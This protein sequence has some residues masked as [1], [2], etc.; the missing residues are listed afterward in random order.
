VTRRVAVTGANGFVGRNLVAAARA[1]GWEVTGVVRSPA[2]AAQVEAA[3]GRAIVVP[4]L[5]GAPLAAAFRNTDAV[6]HLAHIGAERGSDTYEAVNVEGTRRVA[7]AASAA[8]VPRIACFSGLGVAHY[9]M[10]PRTTSRYFLSKLEAETV[11]FRSGLD[12]S[13]FRPSYIVG[14]GDGLTTMLLGDLEKGVV[15]RPGDGRYHMQPVAVADAAAAILAAV[16]AAPGT[17]HRVFDLVG[18]EP[19][20]FD[21]FVARFAARARAAGRKAAYT[22]R[23][24]PMEEADRQARAGGY[25]GML[26]D[27]LD[28]MVCDEVSA[29]APLAALLGR[30]LTPLDTAIDAAIAD[31]RPRG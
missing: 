22:V 21:D 20:A 23:A 5:D 8:G 14:P 13:M 26:P 25:R 3:D 27:E 31:P 17:G 6:V 7:A 16:S 9:G 1:A 4:V 2:G 15:E 19:I 30:P 24:V 28:C 18:P 11:L 29:A 12:V 10:A